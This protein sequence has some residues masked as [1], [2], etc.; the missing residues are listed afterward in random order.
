MML[1]QK[2]SDTETQAKL[3]RLFGDAFTGTVIGPKDERF[4]AARAVWNGAIDARP[5]LIAQCQTTEDIVTAVNLVRAAGSPV[6]VRAGGHSVAG[7]SVCDGGVVIDLSLMRGVAVDNRTAIVEP[8]ATW[9]DFDAA[10]AVHGLATTGGLISTTGVAGLTL[11]GGIGWLQRQYGLS[12]DNLVGA[13]LVTAAGEVVHATA[14]ERP[15][16]LWGLRGG[17][18]NFG[19]VTRFEFALHPVST[20]VGGLMLY[21]LDRGKQVLSAFRDWAADL[22]DAG[23]ML[24]AII[25]APPEPF[26]PAELVGHKAVAILGCWCG[27]VAAGMTA[28]EPLRRLGPAADVF[29]PM[30]YSAL[31]RMLDGGAQHGLRN[32]FRGGYLGELD[33]EVIDVAIEHGARMASPMSQIHFHQMGG[34]LGRV[35][36]DASAFSG[37]AAGYTYNLIST[38]MEAGEDVRHMALNRELAAALAPLSLGGAYVNFLSDTGTDRARA[39][40]GGELYERLARLKR[41]YDPAN[42][43]SRN[44][45]IR[46]AR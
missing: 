13:E 44:Q 46:P 14:V 39:A 24:A 2:P 35:A 32:Y 21:P 20:V 31:Q 30:P 28:L 9:A 17:G 34:A 26:V 40:Y 16:L 1:E 37:R 22:P 42:L 7:F 43:F 23:T 4:D 19:V 15:E 18:G 27:E 6:S 3:A 38:W 11:G 8:G 25:T 36:P 33:D 5:A 41:E 10:T 29:G 12:C 45:N